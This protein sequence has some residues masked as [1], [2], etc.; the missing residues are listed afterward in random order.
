MFKAVKNF[1]L[2]PY[3]DSNYLLKARSGLLLSFELVFLILLVM[4][5]LGMIFIGKEAFLR[6]GRVTPTFVIGSIISLMYLKRGDYKKSA[7][8]FVFV[9]TFG[10]IAGIISNAFIK[11]EVVYTTYIYFIYLPVA[12]SMIFCSMKVLSVIA[13]IIACADICAFFLVKLHTVQ[14]YHSTI[15]LALIDSLITF[16]ILFIIAIYTMRIF[17]RNAIFASEETE[18]NVRKNLFIK[19]TLQVSSNNIVSSAKDIESRYESISHNTQKQVES[20]EEVTASVEEVS[21]GID[22]VSGS[23]MKQNGNIEALLGAM[24]KLSNITSRLNDEVTGALSIAQTIAKKAES[25]E[26]SLGTMSDSMGAISKSSVEMINITSIINDISD[27]I[28]LL[29]LN[30]AIEAARAGDAGRGFA[31][32]A[33]EISKLADQ[34]ASSIKDISRLISVNELEINRGAESITGSVA[35]IREIIDGI[36]IIGEVV[37]NIFRGMTEQ[38]AT[39]QMINSDVAGVGQ[40]AGEIV[41]ATKEQKNAI[42]EIVRAVSVINEYAQINSGQVEEMI[43]KSRL[44]IGM[45]EEMNRTIEEYSE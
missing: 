36:R 10:L 40:H 35:T 34:T 13:P 23:A 2:T 20:T 45:I 44:L 41:N 22:N 18:K 17:R 38:S 4:L 16:I 12:F 24:G 33:D 1:F 39:N 15:K 9:A 25:G 11:P 27:R 32:V 42:D 37:G 5:Q 3:R 21:A 8:I 31:V 14:S 6:V 43:G 19:D 26:K 28:N 7:N 30:A 29:S